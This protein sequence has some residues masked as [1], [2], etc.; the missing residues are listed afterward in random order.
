M[1]GSSMH[2]TTQQHLQHHTQQ[3][4]QQLADDCPRGTLLPL[5]PSYNILRIYLQD[6][7]YLPQLP[8]TTSLM[9]RGT[10]ASSALQQRP[11]LH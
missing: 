9:P 5:T 7:P 11:K 1:L 2:H 6:Q 3:L 8:H 10:T 4:Q